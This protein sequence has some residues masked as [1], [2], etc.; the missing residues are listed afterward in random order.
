MSD[1]W[2]TPVAPGTVAPVHLER[3]R[4]LHGAVREWISASAAAQ[5]NEHIRANLP[6]ADLMFAFGF[7]SVGDPQTATRLVEDARTVLE[8]PIPTGTDV[9]T[10]ELARVA[11]AA[12]FLF[13]LFRYRIEERLAAR[14]H[15]GALCG[16]VL[17][18]H[19]ELRTRAN[20]G[21]AHLAYKVALYD[22]DR[23]REQFAVVEPDRNVDPYEG[24]LGE[25]DPVTRALIHLRTLRDPEALTAQIREHFRKG[26]Q[27]RDLAEVQFRILGEAL[28]LSAR[29]TDP[30][31]AELLTWVPGAAR[32]GYGSAFKSPDQ[33]M[34]R[35]KL[36]ELAFALAVRLG[37]RD[38]LAALTEAL[39]SL[40]RSS[41]EETRPRLAP[42]A[43][44]SC[45]RA[46]LAL[47]PN[48]EIDR[49]LGELKGAVFGTV[50]VTEWRLRYRNRPEWSAAILQTNLVLATGWYHRGAVEPAE[51]A[52]VLARNELLEPTA[53]ALPPLD[54]TELA[55]G[56]VRALGPCTD[57]GVQRFVELYRLMPPRKIT[58]PWVSAQVF[59]RFHLQL[60]E[61][62]VFAVFPAVWRLARDNPVPVV[63]NG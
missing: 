17:A 20:S 8:A 61:E 5:R 40:I 46:L 25:G 51:A 38:L 37:R 42:R 19:E 39:I 43:A 21:L 47:A 2:S 54:Y 12:G 29:V 10:Y 6:Y 28:V 62:T 18:A 33:P 41:D 13:R 35:A 48:D 7:A 9:R 16:E 53:P 45:L 52:F 23:F 22:I 1:I 34:R 4:E 15:A 55:R 56:Y 59:S 24:W 57:A 11:I 50:P 32:I 63:V 49:F 30:F 3:V 44:P 60:V 14:P 31:A 36:L 27:G 26:I 58:N